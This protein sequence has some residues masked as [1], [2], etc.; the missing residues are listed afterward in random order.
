M[1]AGTSR[2]QLTEQT[3]HDQPGPDDGWRQPELGFA[4]ASVLLH[5]SCVITVPQWVADDTY[6]HTHQYSKEGQAYL[7]QGEAV[8]VLEY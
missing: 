7:R 8:I 6:Q 1:Q 2:S 4:D 3:N 5:Q